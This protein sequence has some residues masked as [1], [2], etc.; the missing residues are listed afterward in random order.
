MDTVIQIALIRSIKDELPFLLK[1]SPPPNP[2]ST[3]G[4]GNWSSPPQ[5]LLLGGGYQDKDIEEIVEIAKSTDGAMEIPWLR[6]DVR[7]TQGPPPPAEPTEEQAAVYGKGIAQRMK[8]A[9]NR[10]REEGRLGQGN[11]GIHLV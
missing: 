6:V 9:L 1:G 2:S 7:K 10:L 8:D 3:S 11:G 5:A 4:S